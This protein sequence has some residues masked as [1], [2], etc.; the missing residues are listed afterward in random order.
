MERKGADTRTKADTETE[1]ISEL[2]MRHPPHDLNRTSPKPLKLSDPN[3][4]ILYTELIHLLDL[5][6]MGIGIGE[7]HANSC[8]PVN[9]LPPSCLG[10]SLVNNLYGY[11]MEITPQMD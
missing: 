7:M 1:H 11:D 8:W 2:V 9:W 4:F 3:V 5:L 10:Y 6:S